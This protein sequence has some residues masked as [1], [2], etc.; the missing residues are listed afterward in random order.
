M[1]ASITTSIGTEPTVASRTLVI[2]N[3][4]KGT[5]YKGV[6]IIPVIYRI[7]LPSPLKSINQYI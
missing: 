2:I 6:R 5:I 7:V 1:E 3:A 4:V